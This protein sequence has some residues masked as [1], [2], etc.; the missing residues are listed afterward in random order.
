MENNEEKISEAQ[1]MEP[2]R[3]LEAPKENPKKKKRDFYIE[4]VLFFI[5]G[6]LIGIAVKTEATK[7][8]T[9]GFDDYK[10]KIF[11]QG[12]DINKIQKNLLEKE[13][14]EAQPSENDG[15]VDQGDE[16]SDEKQEIE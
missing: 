2:E 11:E 4:L 13:M 9:M 5:L 6:I 1:I 14:E 16:N 7:R 12:Y 8:I 15:F 10:M 3:I